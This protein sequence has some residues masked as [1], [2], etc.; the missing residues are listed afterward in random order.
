MIVD[1]KGVSILFIAANK[2]FWEAFAVPSLVRII[3]ERG[4]AFLPVP[5]P[6]MT[7][8]L[9]AVSMM[10]VAVGAFITYK[11]KEVGVEV[12]LGSMAFG[13]IAGTAFLLTSKEQQA[14][15]VFA[16]MS[17]AILCDC[18]VLDD[19]QVRRALVGKIEI[20]PVLIS[21]KTR[22]SYERLNKRSR[23]LEV[24]GI[25]VDGYTIGDLF[26]DIKETCQDEEAR[27]EGKTERKERLRWSSMSIVDGSKCSTI[28]CPDSEVR[29]RLASETHLW[30]LQEFLSQFLVVMS[31]TLVIKSL[32]WTIGQEISFTVESLGA[33]YE[34]IIVILIACLVGAMY[35]REGRGGK[36]ILL[37]GILGILEVVFLPVPGLLDFVLCLI[38]LPLT[39]LVHNGP[40]RLAHRIYCI[41]V[42]TSTSPAIMISA[43]TPP[44]PAENVSDDMEKKTLRDVSSPNQNIEIMKKALEEREE[45][46]LYLEDLISQMESSAKLYDRFLKRS[47]SNL[48]SS[49]TES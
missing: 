3:T 20:V 47:K 2:C 8:V 15:V 14:P 46:P 21:A 1:R 34:T 44:Y 5:E 35:W 16:V 41:Y 49:N 27:A 30:K 28:L 43:Y 39:G 31:L 17:L 19:R 36:Q 9:V 22:D 42:K 40:S 33:A 6:Y 38:M 37:F 29:E 4:L 26:W 11:R 32:I 12:C 48:A 18:L 7:F 24:E 10:I 45:Q 25:P 13:W 23:L